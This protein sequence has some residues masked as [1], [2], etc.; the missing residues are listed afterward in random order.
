MNMQ[1]KLQYAS[2]KTMEEH[3][4]KQPQWLHTHTKMLNKMKT[5]RQTQECKDNIG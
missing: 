5:E 3:F 2:Y 1:I 4:H